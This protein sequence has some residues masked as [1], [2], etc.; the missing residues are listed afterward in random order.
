MKA[1]RRPRRRSQPRS[2]TTR[3][4]NWFRI[5]TRPTSWRSCPD[6]VEARRG[7]PGRAA[8]A[9]ATPPP[10]SLAQIR[11]RLAQATDN[12]GVEALRPSIEALEASVPAA[13]LPE[14]LDVKADTFD[15]L[16][17]TADSL[18]LRGR[19]AGIRATAQASPGT[20]PCPWKPCSRLAACSLRT[21]PRTRS[22]SFTELSAAPSCVPAFEVLAEA[23][24]NAGRLDDAYE[25][26]RTALLGNQK[27][28]LL[29][30]LGEVELKRNRLNGAATRSAAWSR[31]TAATT[32]VGRARL[33]R[34]PDGR[35]R[36]GARGPRQGPGGQRDV[37][38]GA[39]GA[40]RDRA[41]RRS[42]RR[43]PQPPPAGAAGQA[44]RPLGSGWL[45][46]TYLASGNAA[47]AAE[48]LAVAVKANLGEFSL[49]LAEAQRRS[50]RPTTLSRRWRP[51]RETTPPSA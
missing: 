37:V 45:G 27:P 50:G 16:G 47:G 20:H 34:R 5:S 38:R 1:A 10:S 8:R 7:G 9:R 41:L 22:R 25:A 4:S 29:M 36:L 32:G 49:A 42:R 33:D 30:S 13:Q 14:V 19:V 35:H 26:L 28:E 17:R 48:K 6:Q 51:R 12:A 39:G 2:R 44:R 18:E 23:Y 24:M 46:A 15:R 43:R 3:S 40:G 21:A 31:S 11:Q